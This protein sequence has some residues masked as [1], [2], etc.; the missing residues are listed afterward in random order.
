MS[1][2]LVE[3]LDLAKVFDVSPPWLNRVVERKPKASRVKSSETF[4][5]G[6]RL[7]S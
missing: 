6:R 4:L 2:P 1:A 7:K 5:V 3:V